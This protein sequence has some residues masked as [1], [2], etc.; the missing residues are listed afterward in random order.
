M[1]QGYVTRIEKDRGYL[2]AE[3]ETTERVFRHWAIAREHGG[4]W[5]KEG[6]Y[7][8]FKIVTGDARWGTFITDIRTLTPPDMPR[9]QPKVFT[10][11]QPT[12]VQ[13]VDKDGTRK[14]MEQVRQE[15][16]ATPRVPV[17]AGAT[18][19]AETTRTHDGHD[20]ESV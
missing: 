4:V 6:A 11:T 7:V 10:Q 14:T 19:P 5:P 2:L 20:Q 9:V 13:R 8:Q 3:G 12:G 15:A 17:H 16:T 1:P 18:P